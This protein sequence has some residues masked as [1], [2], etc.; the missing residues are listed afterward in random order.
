MNIL[1]WILQAAAALLY[2]ASGSMKVFTFDKI[3]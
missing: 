1:L 3:S 2:V